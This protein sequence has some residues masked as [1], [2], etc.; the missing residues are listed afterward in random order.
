MYKLDHSKAQVL[1]LSNDAYYFLKEEEPP[2]DE[3]N[4][5]EAYEIMSMFPNGF[6]I[7]DE[8]SFVEGTDMVEATFVPYVE[9]DWKPDEYIDLFNGWQLQIKHLE[10]MKRVKIRFFNHEKPPFGEQECDV[11]YNDFGKPEIHTKEG[12]IYPIWREVVKC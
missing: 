5:E 6:F 12:S 7:D 10:Y 1:Q 4:L 9:D 3:N 2:I 11:I 8:I